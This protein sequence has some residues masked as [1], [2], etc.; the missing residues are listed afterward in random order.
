MAL[1]ERPLKEGTP[2][3]EAWDKKYPMDKAFR[4]SINRLMDE[5]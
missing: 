3:M 5:V 2:E 1:E 4:A